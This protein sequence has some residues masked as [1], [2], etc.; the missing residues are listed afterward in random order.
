MII[1]TD[2]AGYR[3]KEMLGDENVP[4]LRFGV[5]GGGC[6]GLSYKLGY[7]KKEEET[8][9]LLETKGISIVIDEK[10]VSIIKGTTIDF[11]QSLMGGGFTIENPNAI[12]SCGCGTSFRTKN[13][14]GTPGEC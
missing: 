2:A 14:Q 1:L 6:S 3:I 8:D 13:V 7:A 10:D 9:I 11:K 4:F 12:V 5:T